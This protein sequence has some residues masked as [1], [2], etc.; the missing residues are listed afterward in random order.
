MDDP[1]NFPGLT[2]MELNHATVLQ[3]FQTFLSG[4][5]GEEIKVTKVGE[6]VVDTCFIVEFQ[7]TS[8]ID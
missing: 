3:I 4:A 5:L 7:P 1:S 8:N 2:R 6:R